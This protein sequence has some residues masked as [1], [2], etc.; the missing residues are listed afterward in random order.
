MCYKH[1]CFSHFS[2]FIRKLKKKV[3]FVA[4][5]QDNV[6]ILPMTASLV[7]IPCHMGS[8][9]VFKHQITHFEELYPIHVADIFSHDSIE[10]MAEAALKAVSGKIIPIGLS[11]GGYVAMEMAHLASDRLAGL[12][13]MDSN[14]YSE[15]ENRRHARLAERDLIDRGRY[16]GLTRAGVRRMISAKSFQNE[17]LIQEIIDIVREPSRDIF[18]TQ[19]NAIIAR[20]DYVSTLK[21]LSCSALILCGSE[22]IVTP[23]RLHHDMA[24]LISQSKLIEI[25][26]AGHLITMETPDQVTAHLSDYINQVIYQA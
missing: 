16:S 18:E 11:M 21:N 2:K 22:D 15:D 26:D 3:K 7:F 6:Y 20:R 9:A 24:N 5:F 12:V 19:V 1:N 13:I 4:S 17:A 23:P 14:P 8:A 10:S 25:L